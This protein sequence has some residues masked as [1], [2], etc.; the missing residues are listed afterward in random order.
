MFWVKVQVNG[1][2]KLYPTATC[3]QSKKILC[4][5]NKTLQITNNIKC[6]LDSHGVKQ[7]SLLLQSFKEHWQI[8][9]PQCVSWWKH[10]PWLCK[11]T[12]IQ[13]SFDV[14]F[15]LVSAPRWEFPL[16]LAKC[17]WTINR[18]TRY[19]TLEILLHSGSWYPKAGCCS[20]FISSWLSQKCKLAMSA[21]KVQLG[22]Q[23]EWFYL[24]ISAHLLLFWSVYTKCSLL[25]PRDFTHKPAPALQVKVS[26][27]GFFLQSPRPHS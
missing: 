3:M 26:S 12:L 9:K 24:S 21:C 23:P 14:S 6:N 1:V 7:K 2:I 5:Q 22:T 8:P 19:L 25:L 15:S 10:L 20:T 17:L 18:R 16:A 13:P 11:V 4:R 27:A